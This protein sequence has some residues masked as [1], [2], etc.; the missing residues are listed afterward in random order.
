MFLLSCLITHLWILIK[1]FKNSS[2]AVFPY[3]FNLGRKNRGNLTLVQ[4]QPLLFSWKSMVI[5]T[6]NNLKFWHCW[7]ASPI[8][9][10]TRFKS[11]VSSTENRKPL[12]KKNIFSEPAH[13]KSEMTLKCGISK[14]RLNF[15][16][17]RPQ[18]TFWSV[19]ATNF[20]QQTV[21]SLEK[22]AVL[23]T[24]QKW[25]WISVHLYFKVTETY[26]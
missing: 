13:I 15:R 23:R 19:F 11:L 14:N 26:P 3:T 25:L 24:S 16:R 12:I 10:Y 17:L 20:K 9:S 4:T 18:Q 21:S 7:Y 2:L 22:Q 6:Q 5:S 8:Y 1:R